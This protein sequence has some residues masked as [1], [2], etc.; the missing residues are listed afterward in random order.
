MELKPRE[1]QKKILNLVLENEQSGYNSIIELDCGA[2]KRFLQHQIVSEVFPDKKI[3][4]I[5]QASTSLYETFRFFREV[6]NFRDVELI[7][8]RKPSSYRKHILETSRVVITLPQTL[9]NSISKH[10]LILKQFDIIIINEIDQIVRRTGLGSSIKQ[11]YIKLLP[12]FQHARIIGMSGT[13]RDDHYVLDSAQMKIKRELESLQ[14]HIPHSQLISMDELVEDT[15]FQEYVN[16]T[17]LVLTGVR[18]DSISSLTMELEAHIEEIKNSIIED[19]ADSN[20]QNRAKEDIQLLLSGTLNVDEQKQKKFSQGFLVRKYLWALPGEDAKIHLFRYGLDP[21]W[22]N[23]TIRAMP[24]KFRAIEQ[25]V[26][27]SKKTVILCSFLA[28][29]DFLEQMFR[30][31]GVETVKITG[32]VNQH[33]RD[34]FLQQYRKTDRKMVAIISNVGERDLDLPEADSLIIF[35]VIRTTKTVYQKLKRIRGGT[36]R[37]L[38]YAG[39]SEER[40]ARQVANSIL[41]R[42]PWS[43]K[44]EYIE[45]L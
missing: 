5:M 12:L 41:S 25:I 36:C 34:D 17:K 37:I 22:V 1:Y 26:E 45:T 23:Q 10:P 14:E 30:V 27:T 8:S 4:M 20:L 18:D 32:K 7:D 31:K 28:T 42:Y 16:T 3:I 38:Y 13:L 29:C 33:Q 15:D 44:L 35:D 11:P 21:K 24:A 43:I 19:L 40:K 2:G 6:Y 9:Y 39:T